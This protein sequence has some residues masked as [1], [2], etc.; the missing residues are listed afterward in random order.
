MGGVLWGSE[1]CFPNT[2]QRPR[3]T[4]QNTFS[5]VEVKIRDLA[6]GKKGE[7]AGA[8]EGCACVS[9]TESV[10]VCGVCRCVP[11]RLSACTSM[12]VNVLVFER[13]SA[14]RQVC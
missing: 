8:Y 7:P 2:P 5:E 11:V 14:T 4:L 13:A 10:C 12:S 9:E 6:S 3:L 1:I